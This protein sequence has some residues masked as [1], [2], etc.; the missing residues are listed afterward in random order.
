MGRKAAKASPTRRTDQF[1]L[2]FTMVVAAMRAMAPAA[3]VKYQRD[4]IVPL[5]DYDGIRAYAKT[6][7]LAVVLTRWVL[8]DDAYR[9][10]PSEPGRPR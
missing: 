7:W 9:P 3:P 5:V 8:H 1:H 10:H 2:A 4:R 6:S